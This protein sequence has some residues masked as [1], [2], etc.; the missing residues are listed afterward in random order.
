MGDWGRQHRSPHSPPHRSRSVPRACPPGMGGVKPR[1]QS[2]ILYGKAH[3]GWLT[4]GQRMPAT[5]TATAFRAF[6]GQ[7]HGGRLGWQTPT[8]QLWPAH[9][10]LFQTT[11]KPWASPCSS[12]TLMDLPKCTHRP[13]P[14]RVAGRARPPPFQQHNPGKAC[15]DRPGRASGAGPCL[16][17]CSEDHGRQGALP[18]SGPAQSNCME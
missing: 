13:P 1:A 3:P 15:A 4:R 6:R 11:A 5:R 17:P 12:F 16:R 9:F 7:R 8:P 10:P 14:K 18:H 2:S